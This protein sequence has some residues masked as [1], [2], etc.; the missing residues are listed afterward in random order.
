MFR[1]K[2]PPNFS[3]SICFPF[4]DQMMFSVSSEYF[5]KDIHIHT[6]A[7][8]LFFFPQSCVNFSTINFRTFS[9][10]FWILFI[11]L[12]CRFLLVIHFIHISVYMSIP[13]SQF[14]TPPPAHRRFP[15]LVS[16]CLFSTSVSQ[17]LPCKPV[18][19]YHFLG[20]T[21]MR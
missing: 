20:S 21:Y 6:Y 1:V 7:F 11:F 13:I 15:P 14:I 9:F 18:H 2:S 19:L 10:F 4:L 16:I 5:Q 12:Y 3:R 17:L 8:Y